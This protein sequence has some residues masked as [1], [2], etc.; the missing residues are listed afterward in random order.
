MF[1][2][3]LSANKGPPDVSKVERDKKLKIEIKRRTEKSQPFE[4]FNLKK[5]KRKDKNMKQKKQEKQKN[6][7]R[8]S[9]FT[10]S[11]ARV[12][13]KK[14]HREFHKE[15]VPFSREPTKS[16][17]ERIFF[18]LLAWYLLIQFLILLLMDWEITHLQQ[19][20]QQ[21]GE[22]LFFFIPLFFLTNDTAGET[23]QKEVAHKERFNWFIT[24]V[25]LEWRQSFVVS[26]LFDKL[27]VQI[28][29]I[30]TQ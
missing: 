19:Q 12:R 6:K 22:Y 3:R 7:E 29:E 14:I 5:E 23:T 13:D 16:T 11:T 20:L 25:G 30:F 15:H 2:I 26:I 4:E 1:G 18:L 10:Q 24:L 8:I 17:K 9:Q 27:C 28:N 21:P